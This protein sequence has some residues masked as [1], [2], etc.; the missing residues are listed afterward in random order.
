MNIMN[1]APRY[2]KHFT[3]VIDQLLPPPSNPF[4]NPDVFDILQ[5]QRSA[6]L[7]VQGGDD[8]QT[9]DESAKNLVRRYEVS[10][11]PP[12]S[13]KAKKL[14]EIKAEGELVLCIK[15]LAL[16]PSLRQR[17]FFCVCFNQ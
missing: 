5:R 16:A 6:N 2:V 3:E 8:Q 1:N 13:V 4:I 15:T 7:S 14:R 10:I 12:R 9:L 11:I 17:Y